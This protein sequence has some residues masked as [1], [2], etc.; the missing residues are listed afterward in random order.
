MATVWS[1]SRDLGSTPTLIGHAVASLDKAFYDDDLC[2]VAL[3]KQQI[4]W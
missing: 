3:N 1:Q 4:R 2:L